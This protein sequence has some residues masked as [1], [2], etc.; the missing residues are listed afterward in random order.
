MRV[1]SA[2]FVGINPDLA[3]VL[4]RNASRTADELVVLLNR[5]RP[6]LDGHCTGVP[7][8]VGSTAQWLGEAA[9]DVLRRAEAARDGRVFGFIGPIAA[10]LPYGDALLGFISAGNPLAV[11]LL[12]AGLSEAQLVRLANDALRHLADA[13]MSDDERLMY[14]RAL[15]PLSARLIHLAAA[16]ASALYMNAADAG[17]AAH[18]RRLSSL[19]ERLLL[20]PPHRQ[21]SGWEAF[22]RGFFLGD[23]D[24][25]YTTPGLESARVT[26]QLL[27]GLIPGVDI[28]DVIASARNGDWFGGLLGTVALVPLY[29]DLLRVASKAIG[30][31]AR[32]AEAAD[33]V[34]D[35]ARTADVLAQPLLPAAEMA[36]QASRGRTVL[37][38]VQ[39]VTS[40]VSRPTVPSG[41]VD[42]RTLPAAMRRG[43]EQIAVGGVRGLPVPSGSIGALPSKPDGHFTRYAVADG[44][45]VVTGLDAEL[46][47]SGDGGCTWAVVR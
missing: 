29:G 45:V 35:L 1:T 13:A 19:V 11:R 6:D 4:A 46:F 8:H 20:A 3:V 31:G 40:T 43:I 27:G 7:S 34:R 10:P 25:G 23:F 26:G 32:L 5:L 30:T 39:N 36:A 12:V 17:A 33:R 38:G 28:R 24:E 2:A 15:L 21:G 16:P 9:R 42:L 47:V 41:T 14:R 44:A 18:L 37:V 22:F